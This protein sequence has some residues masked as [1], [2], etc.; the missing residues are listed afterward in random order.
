VWILDN[1]TPHAVV[2]RGRTSRI[3]V[4][5]DCTPDAKL[6]DRIRSGDADLGVRN[7]RADA[8][9]AVLSAFRKSRYMAWLLARRAQGLPVDG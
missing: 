1:L 7:P 8:E 4:V 9:L 3:H 6:A 5:I 2:H